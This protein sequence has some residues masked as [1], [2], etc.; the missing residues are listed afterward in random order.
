MTDNGAVIP[1]AQQEQIGL[2]SVF[3]MRRLLDIEP[4]ANREGPYFR[5]I[6]VKN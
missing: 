2:V 5:L 4:V 1:N 3:R 6:G